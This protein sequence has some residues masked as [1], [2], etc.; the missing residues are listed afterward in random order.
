MDR[1]HSTIQ[2]IARSALDIYRVFIDPDAPMCV[3][4]SYKRRN[5]LQEF[6]TRIQGEALKEANE[7]KVTLN[8]VKNQSQPVLATGLSAVKI[9]SNVFDE[10]QEEIFTL[11]VSDSYRRFRVTRPELVPKALDSTGPLP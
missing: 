6:Y 8:E 3:N 5:A 10:A 4:L 11:M 7:K 1:G 2:N 9:E